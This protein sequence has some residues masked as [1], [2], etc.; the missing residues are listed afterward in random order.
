MKTKTNEDFGPNAHCFGTTI[1]DYGW[2]AGRHNPIDNP[3]KLGIEIEFEG[4]PEGGLNFNVPK[5]WQYHADGSLRNGAE[6]VSNGPRTLEQIEG[7]LDDAIKLFKDQGFVPVFSFRTSLHVHVNV[8]DLTHL[9]LLNMF[10]LYTIFEQPILEMGGEERIGNVHCMPVFMAQYPV[11]ELRRGLQA[12]SADKANRYGAGRNSLDNS[13]RNLMR[14]DLRYSSFNWAA[15]SKFGT[16]EYRSHRGTLDKNDIMKWCRLILRLKE[17]AKT[18][19]NPQQ[20]VQDFSRYGPVM[21]AARIF[22][23]GFDHIAG[24][25]A[26]DQKRLWEGLRHVQMFAFATNDWRPAP[27]K[28]LKAQKPANIH[29]DIEVNPFEAPVAARPN[30]AVQDIAWAQF[31]DNDPAQARVRAEQAR[32]AFRAALN[33]N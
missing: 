31:M 20:I 29:M 9:Q 27:V 30:I 16:I 14:N 4:V 32:V 2:S 28:P 23:V 7:D 24:L 17:A 33:R 19:D 15:V 10:A 25:C 18:Y 5:G 26:K 21:F 1:F 8:N 13:L 3:D 6:I 12:A 11:E 22:P